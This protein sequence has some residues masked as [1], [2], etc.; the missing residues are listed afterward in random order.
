[1]SSSAGRSCSATAIQKQDS[2]ADS[3][4]NN[5]AVVPTVESPNRPQSSHPRDFSAIAASTQHF[6]V[7]QPTPSQDLSVIPTRTTLNMQQDANHLRAVGAF[8]AG[9][10]P[11]STALGALPL[12]L[13]R[14]FWAWSTCESREQRA[15]MHARVPSKLPLFRTILQACAESQAEA[16]RHKVKLVSEGGGVAVAEVG[17]NWRFVAKEGNPFAH[18]CHYRRELWH[19]VM[20]EDVMRAHG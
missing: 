20:R 10:K 12:G 17:S 2:T 4:V 5:Q 8:P 7:D 18:M 19:S 1:M 16:L 3:Q 13:R 6:A 11:T 9:Q 15:Q 14:M